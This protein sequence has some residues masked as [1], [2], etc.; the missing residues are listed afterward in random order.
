MEKLTQS[1]IAAHSE[2][3][4]AASSQGEETYK[5]V[6]VLRAL[7][8]DIPKGTKINGE[9]VR[10]LVKDLEARGITIPTRGISELEVRSLRGRVAVEMPKIQLRGIP[11]KKSTTQAIY[12][13]DDNLRLRGKAQEQLFT[14]LLMQ[15]G[16]SREALEARLEEQGDPLMKLV[17]A[18]NPKR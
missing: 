17:N 1:E 14:F 11:Y 7:G 10:K 12:N 13:T 2:G 3:M 5:V 8:D 9:D 15:E 18:R 4:R 16:D 6:A